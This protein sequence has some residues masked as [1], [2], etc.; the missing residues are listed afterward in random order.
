MKWFSADIGT[1]EEGRV[2]KFKE[3][4]QEAAHRRAHSIAVRERCEGVSRIRHHGNDNPRKSFGI[5][6]WD[7]IN[8]WYPKRKNGHG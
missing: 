6:I 3:K 1:W 8:G 4:N 5:A 2:V 7:D